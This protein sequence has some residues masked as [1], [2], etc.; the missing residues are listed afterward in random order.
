MA[1]YLWEV[2]S[3]SIGN[4]NVSCNYQLPYARAMALN[5]GFD[6]LSQYRGLDFVADSKP[7]PAEEAKSLGTIFGVKNNYSLSVPLS[8]LVPAFKKIKHL[9]VGMG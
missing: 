7:T 1:S 8:V 6:Y 5:S 4:I 2:T 3:Y 9:F